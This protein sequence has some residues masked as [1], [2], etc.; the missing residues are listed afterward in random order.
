M[1]KAINIGGW[2]FHWGMEIY[3]LTPLADYLFTLLYCTYFYLYLTKLTKVS[4]TGPGRCDDR[5]DEKY[6]S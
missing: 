2:G 1:T 6:S 4:L 3:R 5:T